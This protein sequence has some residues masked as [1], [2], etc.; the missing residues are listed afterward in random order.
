MAARDTWLPME[1]AAWET[2]RGLA[3]DKSL[4]KRWPPECRFPPQQRI[5]SS[6][7]HSTRGHEDVLYSRKAYTPYQ[8][9]S[10]SQSY[11][12]QS[13]RRRSSC[14]S[15][16]DSRRVRYFDKS[17]S[18][19]RSPFDQ[20]H[21]RSEYD[22]RGRRRHTSNWR[23]R[24]PTRS[25]DAIFEHQSHHQTTSYSERSK[26]HRGILVFEVKYKLTATEP[27]GEGSVC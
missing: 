23:L 15:L 8:D 27:S 11:R 14:S 7:H 22:E 13:S 2:A 26:L 25:P 16:K 24:S 21:R 19:S 20:I 6:H 3:V 10:P 17:P 1:H 12:S 9:C 4:F 5:S 18:S